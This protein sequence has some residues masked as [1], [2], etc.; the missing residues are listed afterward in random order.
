MKSLILFLNRYSNW[1]TFVGLLLLYLIFPLILFSNA[2]KKIQALAGKRIGPIDTTFGFSPQKT[3]QMVE[4]Y[5]ES[6]RAYYMMVELTIDLAYPV[7]YSLLLAVAITMIYRKLLQ[8]P[9]NY[10]NLLPFA[11]LA[12]DYL[13]N[14]TIILLLRHYPDQSVAMATLCELFK[15]IKWLLFGLVLFVIFFGLIRL[16]LIRKES[17]T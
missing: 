7:V 16:L 11:I 1:R 4:D 10:L 17:V 13:E 14:I 6:G 8:R 2:A 9:V 12:F 15:L 5:G 3:L